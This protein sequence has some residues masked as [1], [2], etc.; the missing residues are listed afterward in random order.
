MIDGENSP[1]QVLN[2]LIAKGA[3]NLGFGNGSA[4]ECLGLAPNV[5]TSMDEASWIR[6]GQS[7]NFAIPYAFPIC[8]TARMS[9]YMKTTDGLIPDEDDLIGG[10][11]GKITDLRNLVDASPDV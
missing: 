4:G 5:L 9:E 7:V 6:A 10:N 2:T 3:R 8:N 1:S 11:V